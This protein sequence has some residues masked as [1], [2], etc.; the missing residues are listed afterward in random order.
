VDYT[1]GM[2]DHRD[3]LFVESDFSG[4]RF[5]GV[6]FSNVRITDAWLQ[7]VELS[8]Q[9]ANL[10]VNGIDVTEYVE[11]ELDARHPERALLAPDTPDGARKAWQ[12]VELFA[13][14]TIERARRM[15]PEQLSESVESEWSFLE[16]M[17]HLVFA[18]DRWISGPVLEDA[19]PFHE[20]GMPNPPL[21]EVP[22]GI[23]DLDATPTVDEVLAVRLDRMDRVA[24][25][26]DTVE[27]DE[28][29]RVVPSP[30]GGT[31]TVR[32]CLHVVF[33]EEWWHD[34][35]A[36]RDLDVIESR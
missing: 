2:E 11:R 7:N 5:H 24:R 29:D 16:T 15:R 14:A 21:D 9:I 1:R 3:A 18:T 36:N 27:V 23:F 12:T 8:G 33:R 34:Q 25:F 35:Y 19:A 31:T 26:V 10:V 20:L 28:M 13:R 4:A 30:N 22:A 17:R 6:D 32:Y